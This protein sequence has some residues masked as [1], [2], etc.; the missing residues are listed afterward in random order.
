M[1]LT[2]RKSA[3]RRLKTKSP[4][5]QQRYKSFRKKLRHTQKK[6][7]AKD[8]AIHGVKNATRSVVFGTMAKGIDTT[9]DNRAMKKDIK[10]SNK[11]VQ[12][13]LIDSI[14]E[15]VYTKVASTIAKPAVRKFVTN[16][17]V[18]MGTAGAVHVGTRVASDSIDKRKERKEEHKRLQH[19]RK[20]IKK[21]VKNK[22][23]KNKHIAKNI[24]ESATVKVVTAA[25]RKV[26]QTHGKNIAKGVVLGVAQK[27][28]GDRIG[29]VRNKKEDKHREATKDYHIKQALADNTPRG[30]LREAKQQLSK[31]KASARITWLNKHTGTNPFL[32]RN[33]KLGPKSTV[34]SVKYRGVELSEMMP[35]IPGGMATL[36]SLAPNRMSALSSVMGPKALNAEK[37]KEAKNAAAS[38]SHRRPANQ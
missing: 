16:T 20:E 7:I 15:N 14:A 8:L 25:A 4:E 34:E 12:K 6:D 29:K 26:I 35:G 11:F 10:K 13:H 19:T 9:F 36:S 38:L 23:I 28:I 32:N 31:T 17:A 27:K 1:L 30:M 2:E 18:S 37:G 33:T 3:R 5:V 21:Y 22:H 24:S